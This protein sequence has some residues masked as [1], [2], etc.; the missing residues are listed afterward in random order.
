MWF[1]PVGAGQIMFESVLRWSGPFRFEPVKT[2][3][4]RSGL[5]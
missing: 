1:D 2:C 5:V 4:S 3:L